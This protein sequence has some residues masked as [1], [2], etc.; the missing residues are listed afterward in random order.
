MVGRFTFGL[1]EADSADI[2]KSLVEGAN[3]AIS[4]KPQT[5]PKENKQ[6]LKDASTQDVLG[7][8]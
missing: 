8:L 7:E 5:I 1:S 3:R 4:L 6:G 2:Q